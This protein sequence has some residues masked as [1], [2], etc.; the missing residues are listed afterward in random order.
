MSGVAAGWQGMGGQ[1]NNIYADRAWVEAK[2]LV[3]QKPKNPW[4]YH[5]HINL[6]GKRYLVND[7]ITNAYSNN[8][9]DIRAHNASLLLTF[10]QSLINFFVNITVLIT[11][12]E[13]PLDLAIIHF[14][15][16]T[17]T[18]PTNSLITLLEIF[19]ATRK[20]VV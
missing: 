6:Y 18:F 7:D 1:W 2:G 15:S 3:Q 10:P 20:C 8:A 9:Q 4:H 5:R 17:S 19:L 11:V 16:T 14:L 13:E 12:S